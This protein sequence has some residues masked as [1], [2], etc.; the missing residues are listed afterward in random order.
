MR[1]LAS[2]GHQVDVVSH[3]PLK[4]PI[5]NYTDISLKDSLP[6]SAN[7]VSIAFVQNYPFVS[8][9]R[10]ASAS[11]IAACTLLGHPKLQ[12]ILRNPPTKPAYDL[13]IVEV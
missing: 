1:G 11:G 7:N 5:P 10:M 12:K 2:R 3:F 9:E 6:E 4:V 8:I 13:V